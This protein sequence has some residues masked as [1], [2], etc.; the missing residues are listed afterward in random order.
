MI[1][2]ASAVESASRLAA[3]PSAWVV[4]LATT[5]VIV[6]VLVATR[7]IVVL[8]R[9]SLRPRVVRRGDWV[10]LGQNVSGTVT[11]IGPW[12]VRVRPPGG[13]PIAVSASHL[14]RL[15]LDVLAFGHRCCLRSG[16]G[17]IRA[18]SAQELTHAISAI[19]SVL[20]LQSDSAPGEL[21]VRFAPD[22]QTELMIEV[23]AWFAANE[24]RA[25]RRWQRETTEAIARLAEQREVRFA[26]G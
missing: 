14:T 19:E 8:V 10:R 26:R 15:T 23:V 5:A 24:Y 3:R 12:R 9:V 18:R 11:G 1:E 4:V 17:R 20:T 21:L 2:G 13:D 16:L 6:G 25:Y 22:S 7:L